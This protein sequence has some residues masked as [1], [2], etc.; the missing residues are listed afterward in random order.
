MAVE[1][2]YYGAMTMRLKRDDGFTVLVDPYFSGN[3]YIDQVS[4]ELY[5]ADIV[6]ITH[7]ASDHY[8][9]AEEILIQ[10]SC[11]KAIGGR[12]VIQ[13]L[14]TNPFISA[15]RCRRTGH[16]D[17]IRLDD[18]AHVR[19]VNAYHGSIV[20]HDAH[21][22]WWPPFG[23]VIRMEPGVVYYHTG[24][25]S[26]FSDMKLIGALYR[27]NVMT[28]GISCMSQSG[29][30]MMTPREAAIATHWVRP[31]VVT[32]AHYLP[33]DRGR[34]DL[35]AYRSLVST[36]EPEICVMDRIGRAFRVIPEQVECDLT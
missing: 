33:D 32:P 19:V 2:T 23:F 21:A 3:P 29:G 10:N 27:P 24:D 22:A 17:L 15:D 16:G 26:I 28:V 13:K 25:S 35:A 1:F 12:E 5:D 6:L 36:L 30:C 20:T 34:A 8:G 14:T 11:V 7:A 18:T 9:D 31:R 4:S